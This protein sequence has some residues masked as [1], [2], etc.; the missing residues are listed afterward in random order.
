[1]EFKP[2]D[3]KAAFTDLS[4]HVGSFA[5]DVA[6]TRADLWALEQAM[7]TTS[8]ELYAAYEQHR[9]AEGYLAILNAASFRIANIHDVPSKL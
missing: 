1:M 7:K 4:Q 2:E 3:L 6:R 5:A 9:K 8:P